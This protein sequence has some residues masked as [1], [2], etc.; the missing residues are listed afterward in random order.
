MSV[1]SRKSRVKSFIPKPPE[2]PRDPVN[3]NA[4]KFFEK[5]SDNLE[6]ALNSSN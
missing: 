6:P 5:K 3:F 4:K 2:T 1:D